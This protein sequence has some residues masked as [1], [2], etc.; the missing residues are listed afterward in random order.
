MKKLFTLFILAS[1]FWL[2][3]P[4]SSHASKGKVH[5][6]GRGHASTGG[7]NV[8]TVQLPDGTVGVAY[9]QTLA[10]S[11]GTGPYTWGSSPLPAGLALHA[12]TGVLDGT[13][14]LLGLYTFTVTVTDAATKTYSQSLNINIA[15]PAGTIIFSDDFETGDFSK[16]DTNAFPGSV[17]ISTLHTHSGTYSASM[18]YIHAAPSADVNHYL[19]KTLA[20][21]AGLGTDTF[22]SG[23]VYLKHPEA[24]A[25]INGGRKLMYIRSQCGACGTA[26]WWVFLQVSDNSGDPTTAGLL[27]YENYNGF[28]PNNS[29]YGTAILNWDTLYH[30]EVEVVASTPGTASTDGAVRWWVNGTLDYAATSINT[31]WTNISGITQLDLGDQSQ[32]DLSGAMNEFR[33]WDDV[34]VGTAFIP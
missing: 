29:H 7:L 19:T 31:R 23:W 27:H 30:V 22:Y 16:W 12:S 6:G 26:A 4:A 9:S 14:T 21:D 28:G 5:G 13:P 33:Y 8:S 32:L 17:T 11:G 3:A 25:A 15:G 34:A 2:L 18:S 24:G 1:S 10:A 20:N